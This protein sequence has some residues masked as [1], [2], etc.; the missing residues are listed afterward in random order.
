MTENAQTVPPEILALVRTPA[1]KRSTEQKATLAAYYRQ[2]APEFAADYA[3]LDSL[4]RGVGVYAEIAQLTETLSAATPPLNTPS[5]DA[6]RQRL[7][8][9][10]ARATPLPFT[11]ARNKDLSLPVPITRDAGF[12]AQ[13]QV[14]LE[15]FSSGRDPATRMESPIAPNLVVS[16]LTIGG[17]DCFGT[18]NIRPAAT[19]ELGTRMVVLR[20]ETKVGPD[21]YVVYSDAF[22]LTVTE[23]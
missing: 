23:K 20:A 14:S 22:P 15:G 7:E 21:T 10:K 9:L 3:K 19:C 17:V 12:T 2:I 18:L 1:D 11:V 8:G 5:L 6:V 13:V 16:P 4:R